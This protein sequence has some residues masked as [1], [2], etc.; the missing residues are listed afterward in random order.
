MYSTAGGNRKIRYSTSTAY[1]FA[2]TVKVQHSKCGEGVCF[3]SER[4]S[5]SATAPFPSPST[6]PYAKLHL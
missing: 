3:T 1:Y 5:H 6:E 2:Q 4:L